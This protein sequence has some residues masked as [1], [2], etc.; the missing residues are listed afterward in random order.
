MLI[1]L[2]ISLIYNNFIFL[3][4]SFKLLTK[5]TMCKK[6]TVNSVNNLISVNNTIL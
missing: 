6:R 3:N 4:I 1:T 5:Q 2:I